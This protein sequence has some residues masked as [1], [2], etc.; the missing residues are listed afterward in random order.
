VWRFP[1]GAAQ[2]QRRLAAHRDVVAPRRS[3]PARPFVNERNLAMRTSLF[4]RFAAVLT[5]FG[6]LLAM[7]SPAS[8]LKP[9][10][11][12]VHEEFDENVCGVDVHTVIDGWSIFHIQE[13]VIESTGEG[14][15]DFWIG[16]IQDHYDITRTNAA[17]VTMT[18]SDRQT[19]Q[20]D[21]LV[22]I[23]D[24]NWNYTFSVNGPFTLRVDNQIVIRDVGRISYEFVFHLGDLST[25]DD[26]EFISYKI[27]SSGGSHPNPESDFALFCEVFTDIM[28]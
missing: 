3:V 25:L 1:E 28:G 12:F 11:V 7:A 19:I 15:D 24:G 27:I 26:N 6:L 2:Q 13:V 20:E 5:V 14:S 9:E 18:E 10:K 21:D 4:A 8:A 16:V 17:G 23:G 22:D